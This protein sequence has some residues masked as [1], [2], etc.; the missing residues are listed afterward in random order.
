MFWGQTPVPTSDPT[1]IADLFCTDTALLGCILP[2]QFSLEKLVTMTEAEIP[3]ITNIDIFPHINVQGV[4]VVKMNLPNDVC[5]PLPKPKGG[6]FLGG[7][8]KVASDVVNGVLDSACNLELPVVKSGN[9]PKGFNFGNFPHPTSFPP[10]PCPPNSEPNEPNNPEDPKPEEPTKT[11]EPSPSQSSPSS[12]C[13]QTVFS[14]CEVSRFVSDTVTRTTESCSTTTACTGLDI[15]KISATTACT[16]STFRDCRGTA[17]VTG[18]GTTSF[19]TE[20]S[21]RSAC[22]GTPLTSITTLISS[23]PEP[24]GTIIVDPPMMVEEEQ[25]DCVFNLLKSDKEEIEL[26]D[27]LACV[28]STANVTSTPEQT[29]STPVV[30]LSPSADGQSSPSV[31][32]SVQS[33]T[34]APTTL[35]PVSSSS[36]PVPSSSPQA[37]TPSP[38]SAPVSVP[39][40]CHTGS[41]MNDCKTKNGKCFCKPA[42]CFG[43]PDPSYDCYSIE[44][45]DCDD[46]CK[47]CKYPNVGPNNC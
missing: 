39:K 18:G 46:D 36:S 3:R 10:P 33:S 41:P 34:P 21:T 9:L 22:S 30:T 6:G 29:T 25:R 43:T 11:P 26:S 23:S 20:C 5:K 32:P 17:F 47:G 24:T 7:V 14:S 42:G 12:S 38:S 27:Y 44:A 37:P 40:P 16:Q 4:D 35:S 45:V 28:G 31:T 8:F 13:S 15:T 1:N 19:A 2:T